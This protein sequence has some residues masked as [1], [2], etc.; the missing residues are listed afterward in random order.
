MS[1]QQKD[2]PVLQKLNPTCYIVLAL[3]TKSH[4]FIL[5]PFYDLS[6]VY[7][8]QNISNCDLIFFPRR[9]PERCHWDLENIAGLTLIP[10]DAKICCFW[11]T[12]MFSALIHMKNNVEQKRSRM[13][14]C[15]VETL[16][17]SFFLYLNCPALHSKI[18]VHFPSGLKEKIILRK[19]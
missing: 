16:P 5:L 19:K 2:V 18:H 11:I 6:N 10:S 8:V 3:K 1:L 13:N 12:W 7:H 17:L 15:S 4:S 9:W 14:I